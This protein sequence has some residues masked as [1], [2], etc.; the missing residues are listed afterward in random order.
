[1]KREAEVGLGFRIEGGI[2][3]RERREEVVVVA[4]LIEMAGVAAAPA[5]AHQTC[6]ADHESANASMQSPVD[7]EM[8]ARRRQLG[9]ILWNGDV[10]GGSP[11]G[12]DSW[13]VARPGSPVANHRKED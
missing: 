4:G 8:D 7:N 2:G 3:R 11:P 13:N 12:D 6:L 1:M 5:A 9:L 10:L